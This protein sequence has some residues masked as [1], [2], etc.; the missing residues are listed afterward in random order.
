MYGKNLKVIIGFNQ[1]EV[2]GFTVRNWK[3]GGSE[4]LLQRGPRDNEKG[5]VGA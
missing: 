3:K 2:S 1:A 4:H 5:E